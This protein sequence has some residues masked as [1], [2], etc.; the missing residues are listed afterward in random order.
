MCNRALLTLSFVFAFAISFAQTTSIS[1]YSRF[2]IGEIHKIGTTPIYGLGGLSAPVSDGF[3][4]NPENPASYS[5]LYQTTF[6]IG[7]RAQQLELD[8]G[9]RKQTLNF[10]NLNHVF[11]NMKRSG[12][13]WGL[14]F[15]LTPYSSTGYDVIVD[16]EA[17]LEG[18][19]ADITDSYSGQGGINKGFIGL[20]RKFEFSEYQTFTDALGAVTD[21]VRFAQHTISLGVNGAYFF[22][23]IEEARRIDFEDP[24]FLDTRI[25][26][27][28]KMHSFGA[29]F[30]LQYATILSQKFT[31]DKKIKDRW[32]IKAGLTYSPKMEWSTTYRELNE[33]IQ[34]FSLVD[35]PV[36]TALFIS[37][38]GFTTI[39]DKLSAGLALHHIGLKGKEWS[40]GADIKIQ[41]WTSASRTIEGEEVNLG[42]NSSTQLSVGIQFTPTTSVGDE[43]KN[44]FDRGNYFLG[45]R[46]ETSYLTLRDVEIKDQAFTFGANFPILASRSLTKINFGMEIGQRGTNE[47]LLLKESYMNFYIGVS[48]SPFQ[49]NV[50]FRE[51]KYD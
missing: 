4:I 6:Q 17:E 27:D 31:S 42:L 48:L 15:G 12:S 21:S 8:N 50:W 18:N 45:F 7:L 1:S 28:T 26:V 24:N 3:F 39:P 44:I 47:S 32:M 2:G 51:R 13:P 29:D 19:T 35:I 9:S 11:I 22:G 41:D 33:T 40:I 5:H 10:S 37:G 46:D 30:G 14:V 43:D 23:N 20:S 38:G 49:K 25:T 16:R 34:Q 36:D